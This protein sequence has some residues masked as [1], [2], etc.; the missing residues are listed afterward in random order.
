M[1]VVNVISHK[2]GP[3]LVGLYQDAF[4]AFQVNFLYVF[5]VQI[6]YNKILT[7]SILDMK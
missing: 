6:K 4:Q 3:N 7:I 2:L 1:Y 5:F